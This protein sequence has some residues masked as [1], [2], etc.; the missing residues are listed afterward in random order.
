MVDMVLK[1]KN[2]ITSCHE[3]EINVNERVKQQLNQR[4]D[5]ILTSLPDDLKNILKVS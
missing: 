3:N 1:L 2:K 4:L 5:D